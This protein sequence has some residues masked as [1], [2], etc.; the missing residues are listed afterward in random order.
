MGFLG[1]GTWP[2]SRARRVLVTGG[3]GFVG[4]HAVRSLLK[5]GAEVI[6]VGR[7]P[8]PDLPAEHLHYREIDLLRDCDF[9]ALARSAAADTLLH[10]AWETRHG[11]F[12]QAPSN[13][14]WV[15]SSL[16]LIENF[17]AA[18]GR[19]VVAAGTC[20]EYRP[21][22]FG[23]C[24][25]GDTPIA[26]VHLYAVAKDAL[27]RLLASYAAHAGLS[28]AWGRVFFVH[29]PGEGA[30][31]LVP[32]AICALM[33]GEPFATGAG[34][35]VR[36]FL[37]ARD[38]GAAFAHLALGD[39]VGPINVSSGQPVTIAALMDHLG[40]LTGRRDLIEIGK[41]ATGTDEPGNL[42]GDAAPLRAIVGFTPRFS[43]R[44]S[45]ETALD[46]WKQADSADT[47]E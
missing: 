21:P 34:E 35:R 6:A 3:G 18:G 23:P 27:H 14:A 41:L 25:A 4:R 33:K 2:L 22:L 43:L 17:A 13:L 45:L 36:D 31:R 32:S 30:K 15:A 39:Y 29:G 19:R 5:E 16:R 9:A 28:Y 11:Y 47:V 20:V 1:C 10:L 44:Q 40:E 24:I 12:W 7:R 38:C 37:D 46:L 26:P 42:W 8:I